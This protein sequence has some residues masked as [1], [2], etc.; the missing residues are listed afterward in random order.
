MGDRYEVTYY[1]CWQDKHISA[2]HYH[3]FFQAKRKAK[4]LCKRWYCVSIVMR[5]KKV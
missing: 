4:Q 1:D 5:L 3:W 2:G